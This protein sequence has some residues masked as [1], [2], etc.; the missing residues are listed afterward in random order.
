MTETKRGRKS[1]QEEVEAYLR[2]QGKSIDDLPDAIFEIPENPLELHEEFRSELYKQ[3]KRGELKSTAL[4]QG[5]K[6]I[7]GMA[8]KHLAANPPKVDVQEKGV[9]EVL[10]DA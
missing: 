4:V 10:V 8:E 2:E 9:D 3:M 7:D 5:L 6:A 1:R